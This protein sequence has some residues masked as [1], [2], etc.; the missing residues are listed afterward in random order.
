MKFKKYQHIEKYGSEETDGIL[1]GKVYVFPKIDGT[2][3]CVYLNDEGKLAFGGRR[4]Q[5]LESQDN[6]KFIKYFNDNP[7]IKENLIKMLSELPKYTI[8]YGEW[9]IP[10]TLKTYNKDAWRQFYIFDVVSY[11]DG[12]TE[13]DF[14]D[15]F[16]SRRLES[17]L[18]YD[19][20]ANL[21]EKFHLKYIPCIKVIYN[22]KIEEIEA[23]LENSTY[24]IDEGKGL[25]EGVIIKN[26]NYKNIYGRRTWAKLITADFRDKK[27]KV[28]TDY[29]EDKQDFLWEH[30]FVV[31]FC[32]PEFISK[33]VFKFK[34]LHPECFNQ[35]KFVMKNFSNLSTYIFNELIKD[36]ILIAINEFRDLELNFRSLRKLVEK[37]IKDFVL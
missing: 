37:E 30:K 15:D 28:R 1:N 2:N 17:Y 21:C 26:Y 9:L 22:P 7:T 6:Y 34:E 18:Y 36:N 20:Y 25:G 35:N 16:K 8:I 4:G 12:I 13:E 33:E 23:E 29:H 24:L 19:F 11:P 10:V 32:N 3:C 31:R 5:L 27:V 14:K